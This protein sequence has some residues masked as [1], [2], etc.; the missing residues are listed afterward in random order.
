MPVKQ[1]II[2]PSLVRRCIKTYALKN[3]IRENNAILSRIGRSRNWTL[4]AGFEQLDNII[5]A[6]EKSKEESWLWVAVLLRQQYQH[7]NHESLVAIARLNSG[8]TVNELV[9]KTSCSVSDARRV[10][11]EIEWCEE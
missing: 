8:I 2:L 6:I 3:L 4:T 9:I 1:H 5:L 11:D 10:I 7:L